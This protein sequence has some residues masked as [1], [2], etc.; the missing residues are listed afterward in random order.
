MIKK[1]RKII[2]NEIADLKE[3]FDPQQ[4][5]I[6]VQQ[7]TM[8]NLSFTAEGVSSLNQLEMNT[9][10]MPW[11]RAFVKSEFLPACLKQGPFSRF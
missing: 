11:P 3:H 5:D 9:Q 2:D 10:P 6:Q 1:N 4:I 8:E 7:I